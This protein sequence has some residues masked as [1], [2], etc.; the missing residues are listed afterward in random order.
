MAG[1][2]GEE[3]RSKPSTVRRAALAPVRQ[4]RSKRI[5]PA[6]RAGRPHGKRVSV[7]QD[8][9]VRAETVVTIN[10]PVPVVY[11]FWQTLENLPRFMRHVESVTVLDPTHSHWRVKA[12]GGKT[13][14]WD[15]ETIEQEENRMIS[16]RSLPEADVD[17]AGSVWF[18]PVPGGQGTVVRVVLKYQPP[19]G[20][21]GVMLAKIFRQDAESEIEADLKQLKCILEGESDQ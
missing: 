12:F 17:S 8:K 10:R 1:L 18:T 20:K 2:Q 13:L 9:G 14:E 6:D 16:W 19:G 5:A 11:Q 7:P 21:A 3:K 15:A 4:P